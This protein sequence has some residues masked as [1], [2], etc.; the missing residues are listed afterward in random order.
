MA[1]ADVGA[2]EVAE[3]APSSGSDHGGVLAYLKAHAAVEESEEPL[4]TKIKK[5]GAA[6]LLP[7]AYAPA[8]S[9]RRPQQLWV[10]HHRHTRR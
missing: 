4:E 9:C 3:D 8:V 7:I 5:L 10:R 6:D 1:R 2:Q